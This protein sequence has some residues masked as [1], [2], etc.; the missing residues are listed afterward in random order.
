MHIYIYTVLANPTYMCATWVGIAHFACL[1]YIPHRLLSCT[2]YQVAAQ[3][4]QVAAQ[5]YQIAAQ[6]YQVAAKV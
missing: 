4:Y 1:Q 3:V 2:K 5:V 6:V